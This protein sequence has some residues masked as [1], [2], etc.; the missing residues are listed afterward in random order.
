MLAVPP[1]HRL[2]SSEKP[3][4]LHAL[5]GANVLLLDD[6][7]C[8]REQALSW[9]TRAHL[10]EL[11]YRATSL[12][13]LAQM[14]ADGAGI[15][16]LPALSVPTETQRRALRVRA[17]VRPRFRNSRQLESGRRLMKGVS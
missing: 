1:G 4:N 13:T 12:P 15:T 7:H 6:G 5:A 2:A 8:F 14:V 10:E 16:L 3:V 9:C 17:F 11:D